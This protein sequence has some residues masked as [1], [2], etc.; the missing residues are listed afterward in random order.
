MPEF[1]TAYYAAVCSVK[2]GEAAEIEMI[3]Q[4]QYEDRAVTLTVTIRGEFDEI[5]SEV[6]E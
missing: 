2:D 3:W 4:E 1:M 5:E 6:G